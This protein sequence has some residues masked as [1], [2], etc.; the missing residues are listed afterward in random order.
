MTFRAGRVRA[1]HAVLVAAI[2]LFL[3]QAGEAQII[4]GRLLEDG[5]NKPISTAQ[6]TL[7]QEGQGGVSRVVT[8]TA[9]RFI[10]RAPGAG[11]YFLRGE[12]IA[13]QNALGPKLT[14]LAGDTIEV[15]FL[16]SAKAILLAPLVV[17]ASA[18]DW[19]E[20]YAPPALIPF[21]QRRSMYGKAG[22]GRFVTR[23]DF[24]DMDAMPVSLY[25]AS[26]IPGVRVVSTGGASIITLRSVVRGDCQ[27]VFYLNGAKFSPGADALD[28]LI[29]LAD[30]EAMEVYRG[31]AEIPGEFTGSDA[32][33]GVIVFWTRRTH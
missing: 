15:E 26:T 33:C 8:D 14:L 24:K 27:P 11:D 29:R 12:H 3:A 32:E 2:L 31:A 9:G 25:L 22:L 13:Y 21:Y 4:R 19:A 16:M 23:E 10:I 17:T 30:L 28:S 18:R 7:L 20:R 6:I 1:R 5:S